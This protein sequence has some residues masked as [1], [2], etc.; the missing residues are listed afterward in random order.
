MAQHGEHPAR[1]ECLLKMKMR[2]FLLCASLALSLIACD[3][4]RPPLGFEP[5]E[6]PSGI[7]GLPYTATVTITGNETPVGDIYVA[8]GDLP[9]GVRLEFAGRGSG[10]TAQFSGTPTAAGSYDVTVAAWCLGTN[11]SGQTG[12]KT[13]TIQIQ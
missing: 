2:L 13:Y 12:E 5:S 11:V 10:S 4:G 1:A 8:E 6:L 9:P 3:A 7:V